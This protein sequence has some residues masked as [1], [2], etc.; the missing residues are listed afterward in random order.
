VTRLLVLGVV[1]AAACGNPYK[2]ELERNRN[3]QCNDRTASYVVMAARELASRL[4]RR[5]P[6]DH[7]WKADQT[8]PATS[9]PVADRP[10]FERRGEDHSRAALLGTAPAAAATTRHTLD[11]ND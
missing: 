6:A 11:V 4:P 7:Q 3:F 9:R 1:G 8:A 10:E 2:E 5:R